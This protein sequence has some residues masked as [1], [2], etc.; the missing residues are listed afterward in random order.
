MNLVGA[1]CNCKHLSLDNISVVLGKMSWHLSSAQL[2]ET[3][4]NWF[5]SQQGSLRD[6]KGRVGI[7]KKL[8]FL[9][10]A[11]RLW[12]SYTDRPTAQCS[13][14]ILESFVNTGSDTLNGLSFRRGSCRVDM[15]SSSEREMK[16]WALKFN[17][18]QTK[19]TGVGSSTDYQLRHSLFQ[20][21]A[22][23]SRSGYQC[24]VF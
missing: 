2:E 13:M 24:Y 3:E 12:N 11:N 14:G 18:S 5:P 4:T 16:D 15:Q 6:T 8:L 7:P 21:L 23:A 20:F 10:Q 9:P 1:S 17:F 19:A 22:N